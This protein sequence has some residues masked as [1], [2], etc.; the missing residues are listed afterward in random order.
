M[1]TIFQDIQFQV[2]QAFPVLFNCEVDLKQI[3]I[4]ETPKEFVG[5]ITLVVFPLL[6]LS[7]KNEAVS[8]GP[9]ALTA[10]TVDVNNLNRK[11]LYIKHKLT[12]DTTFTYFFGMPGISN[13]AIIDLDFLF[14]EFKDSVVSNTISK[15]ATLYTIAYPN[16][17][18]NYGESEIIK[19]LC[20]YEITSSNE[21]TLRNL[22]NY[23]HDDYLTIK[24]DNNN[25]VLYMK[26]FGYYANTYFYGDTLSTPAISQ[27]SLMS[28]SD[29]NSFRNTVFWGNYY[30]ENYTPA[31]DTAYFK[32]GYPY[33]IEKYNIYA[34]KIGSNSSEFNRAKIDYT[35]AES[36]I[37]AYANNAAGTNSNSSFFVGSLEV[38]INNINNTHWKMESYFYTG[39]KDNKVLH[40]YYQ[41]ERYE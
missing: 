8:A 40:G 4:N 10:P 39:Y 38:L 28:F 23:Q 29:T 30:N 7:K 9:N 15:V 36:N 33:P 22:D 14:I 32:F 1:S 16:K 3:T 41:G 11:C 6:K 31:Y 25:H 20:S 19:K 26:L 37:F 18:S 34:S 21:I 17:N 12:V 2:Q 5:D 13:R 24:F 27:Y 35:L